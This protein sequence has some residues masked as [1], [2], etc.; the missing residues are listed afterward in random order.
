MASRGNWQGRALGPGQY[1]RKQLADKVGVSSETLK[2]WQRQGFIVPI[3]EDGDKNNG[4]SDFY[5]FGEQ[6]LEIA[7]RLAQL[8]KYNLEARVAIIEREFGRKSA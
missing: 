1:T 3:N 7:R 5:I 2:R 8:G 4:G 6:S